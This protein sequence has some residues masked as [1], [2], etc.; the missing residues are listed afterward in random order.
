MSVVSEDGSMPISRRGSSRRGLCRRGMMGAVGAT[1]AL[2]ASG[3]LAAC[4]TGGGSS[5]GAGASL[6]SRPTSIE[7]LMDFGAT[8][9]DT[10]AFNALLARIK[11]LSPN[12]NVTV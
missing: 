4:Q 6:V 9:A 11:E 2:T 1:A 10:Q 7:V 8:S 5:G 3:V 12:L